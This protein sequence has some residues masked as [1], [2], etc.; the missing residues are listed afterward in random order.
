MLKGLIDRLARQPNIADK[1]GVL[2]QMRWSKRP[3]E[4]DKQNQDKKADRI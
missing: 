4:E 1:S 3:T 2:S